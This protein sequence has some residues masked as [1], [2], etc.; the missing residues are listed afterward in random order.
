[1]TCCF[2]CVCAPVL[3][4]GV[5]AAEQQGGGPEHSAGGRPAPPPGQRAPGAL[6]G[7]HRRASAHARQRGLRRLWSTG[8]VLTMIRNEQLT[9]L[10]YFMRPTICTNI[11]QFKLCFRSFRGFRNLLTSL[12]P[13][14]RSNVAVHQFGHP[15]LHRVL[16]HPQR[17]GCPL[18]Q[19]PVP[20]PGPTEHLGASGTKCTTILNNSHTNRQSPCC[21]VRIY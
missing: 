16:W 6:P 5:G 12:C 9:T 20:H 14:L 17:A 2:L 8:S 11:H 19:D 7:N 15:D 3:Q 13:Y 4:L 21:I 10:I 18:L 1:L